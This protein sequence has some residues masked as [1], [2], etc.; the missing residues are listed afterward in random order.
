MAHHREPL[1]SRTREKLNL[2]TL[3]DNTNLLRIHG[4]LANFS[5]NKLAA[6]PTAPPSSSK[7]VKLFAE[8][9]HQSLDHQGYQVVII[10][11]YAQGIYI[12][13]E[14]KLL[15]SIAANCV[16]HTHLSHLIIS[17]L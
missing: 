4:R 6:E 15:K 9:M 12:L 10:V 3:E 14:K 13:R 5:Y 7:I 2:Q 16:N 17:G 1:Q 8:H 11:L